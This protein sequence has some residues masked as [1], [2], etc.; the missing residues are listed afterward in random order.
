[1]TRS[2]LLLVACAAGCGAAAPRTA[3]IEPLPA[4][5]FALEDGPR[6]LETAWG[7]ADALLSEPAPIPPASFATLEEAGTWSNETLLPWAH[8]FLE[9][10]S[11]ITDPLAGAVALDRTL[12]V[13]AASIA[14]ALYERLLQVL[15]HVP[16]PDEIAG[17]PE[18]VTQY[19]EA[20]GAALGSTVDDT[21]GLL[22]ECVDA[23]PERE[24][25]EAW[26]AD[27]AGRAER[28]P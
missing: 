11:A 21:R 15:L 5:P 18:L 19:R 12:R 7:R 16:V 27:C 23:A 3:R 20:F 1:M 6:E 9:R 8:Q 22:A 4:L 13:F 17:D 26:G 2:L 24:G 14:A 10:M 28:L 25:A